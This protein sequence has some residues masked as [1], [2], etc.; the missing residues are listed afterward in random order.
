MFSWTMAINYNLPK[1]SIVN[2]KSAKVMTWNSVK[3]IWDD[4]NITETDFDPETGKV[5]FRSLHFAP[6]ALVQVF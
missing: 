3:K 4:E 1:G 2:Q 6:T 5:R